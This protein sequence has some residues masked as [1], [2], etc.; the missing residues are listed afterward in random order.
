MTTE[1]IPVEPEATPEAAP[2]AAPEA[3]PEEATEAAPEKAEAAPDEAPAP[4]RRGRPPR[5]KNRPRVTP[6]PEEEEEEEEEEVPEPP[7]RVRKKPE[8]RPATA[9]IKI[10]ASP[11]APS[12]EDF[13][14]AR[15][16]D[17]HARALQ[18]R[19]ARQ[20]QYTQML[21]QKMGV[22]KW[23]SPT[24]HGTRRSCTRRPA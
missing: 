7:K 9:P 13:M 5:S 8:A 23:Q 17:I 24:S 3:T 20:S 6:P 11:P 2:E 21:S 1:L 10:L 4:K 12:P 14:R 22:C 18:E 19:A 16:I 15:M